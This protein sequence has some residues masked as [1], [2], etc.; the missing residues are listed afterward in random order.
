MR[1]KLTIL[2]AL[3]VFVAFS[4]LTPEEVGGRNGDPAQGAAPAQGRTSSDQGSLAFDTLSLASAP[5]LVRDVAEELPTTTELAVMAALAELDPLVPVKS[6]PAALGYALHA[7]YSYKWKNPEK[8]RKP[9]F[10]FVDFGLDSRTPR[11]YVFDMERL[12]VVEGPFM[13]A[14]GNGSGGGLLPT[15]FL[16]RMDSNATSLGL[17][18]AE[19]TYTFRG[20]AGG[21]SY[22]SLGLRLDGLSGA[23]NG[24]ARKRGIVVHGAPYVTSKRAG[25]SEGCPAMELDRAQR[26]IP[27]IADGGM[28]FHFSPLDERWMREDPWAAPAAR[29]ALAD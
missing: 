20:R 24:A 22:R 8:V 6:H 28:V 27:L 11:G 7:Y 25:R 2:A 18:L 19:E 4:G 21:R 29:L 12:T 9:Y 1:P 17:Y 14:H 5:A 3:S 10:Y 16:N 26:L 13:V 15:R 23:F